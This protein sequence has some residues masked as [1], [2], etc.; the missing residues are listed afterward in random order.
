MLLSDLQNYPDLFD[1]DA[2]DDDSNFAVPHPPSPKA[3]VAFKSPKPRNT[4]DS[5][6]PLGLPFATYNVSADRTK[7]LEFVSRWRLVKRYAFSLVYIHRIQSVSPSSSSKLSS[8]KQPSSASKHTRS[9]NSSST[10]FRP[11]DVTL[12]QE[13]T[14]FLAD[15]QKPIALV[16]TWE[17]ARCY[18]VPFSAR[19]P[20]T[21]KSTTPALKLERIRMFKEILEMS[22][23]EKIVFDGKP[24][25]KLLLSL[26]ISVTSGL[27]DPRIAAWILEPDIHKDASLK[28]LVEKYSDSTTVAAFGA[29][30]SGLVERAIHASL[31]QA[32][33]SF[34]LSGSLDDELRLN[35]Q[36]ELYTDVEM[37]LLPILAK[38]EF[39]GVGFSSDSLLNARHLVESKIRNLEARAFKAAR[40]EFDLNSPMEVSY[41]L[42]EHLKLAYPTLDDLSSTTNSSKVGF[43]ASVVSSTSSSSKCAQTSTSN[44]SSSSSSS[45]TSSR[46]NKSA[47]PMRTKRVEKSTKAEILQAMMSGPS[48]HPL[49]EIL[50]EHRML[51][52]TVNNYMDQLPQFAFHSKQLHMR[53]IYSTCHQTC[54]PTGRLAFD[55]PNLQSIRHAFEFIPV[56][57]KRNHHKKKEDTANGSLDPPKPLDKHEKTQLNTSTS[58]SSSGSQDSKDFSEAI[59]KSSSP[60]SLSASTSSSTSLSTTPTGAPIEV[61]I[62]DAFIAAP[63]FTLVSFDY[64]QLEL[65]I[66]AHFADD[67]PLLQQLR[68][69]SVDMFNVV[70]AQWLLKSSLDVRPEERVQA[71]HIC[72]A[73]LYGQGTHALART[74]KVSKSD[75]KRFRE[76]FNKRFAGLVAFT[77]NVVKTTTECGYT[78]TLGGRRRHFPQIY[79]IRGGGVGVGAGGRGAAAGGWHEERSQREEYARAVRQ[80]TNTVCQGSAADIVKMATIKIEEML[81]EKAPN[82]RCIINLHDELVYELP[83]S[84]L[85][86][87]IPDIQNIMESIMT[88]KLPLTVRIFFGQTWGHLTQWNNR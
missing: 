49:P 88:L 60:P 15:A 26:G 18:V 51:S 33:Q 63:N 44:A 87:L 67:A 82:G 50:L 12:A 84:Q 74:L 34:L 68:D 30:P 25:L 73:I 17:K 13:D 70:A 2:A 42:F 69:P 41:I 31:L 72:Y 22:D 62:R 77:K 16:V 21:P 80:I 14:L 85:E 46:N 37:R 19:D 64:C 27:R 6:I 39:Y 53:R 81:T 79:S 65:R 47:A 58:T 86:Q 7:F 23:S 66:M 57:S 52:H 36:Y 54:V 55:H 59:I 48:P 11:S 83:T 40:R 61:N 9:L 20:G 8:K 56:S 4:S 71:K 76:D 75:A 32:H 43:G 29:E 28:E 10:P 24:Q 45:S 1:M 35:S 5:S 78:E 3:P 38:M